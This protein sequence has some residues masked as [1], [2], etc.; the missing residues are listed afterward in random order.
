MNEFRHRDLGN[1]LSLDPE[2]NSFPHQPDANISSMSLGP[3]EPAASNYALP[4]NLTYTS[5]ES[6]DPTSV[7]MTNYAINSMSILNSSFT[8]VIGWAP[9]DNG[10]HR[11]CEPCSHLQ[12][13]PAFSVS[14][15]S[16]REIDPW[17]RNPTVPQA[18]RPRPLREAHHHYEV[19]RPIAHPL[20]VTAVP[21]SDCL[22]G[23]GLCPE[24][25]MLRCEWESTCGASIPFDQASINR[26]VRTHIAEELAK[27][28][29]GV[30]GTTMDGKE[31]VRYLFD[32][33]RSCL[34]SGITFDD[35]EVGA[36]V[37]MVMEKGKVWARCS[38][39]ANGSCRIVGKKDKGELTLEYLPRHIWG[40]HF[41]MGGRN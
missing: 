33:T 41:G 35:L 6:C 14:N 7:V 39:G 2:M 34:P 29:S 27:V 15:I 37:R 13:H 24:A 3:L 18:H 19:P 9:L 20:H 12:N 36:R 38:W 10:I 5:P 21:P 22:E 40:I 17:L 16:Y 23:L 28:L 25:R 11:S 1:W 26:H 31:K 32:P 8:P 4:T 30:V